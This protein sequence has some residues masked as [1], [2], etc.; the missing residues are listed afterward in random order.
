MTCRQWTKNMWQPNWYFFWL[1]W[2]FKRYNSITR[3]MSSIQKL[4]DRHYELVNRY[5]ILFLKL[6][7]RLPFHSS[8]IDKTFTGQIRVTRWMYYKKQNHLT[9]GSPPPPPLVALLS[10]LFIVF[11]YVRSVTCG[12]EIHVYSCFMFFVFLVF[13]LCRVTSVAHVSALSI[14]TWLFSFFYRLLW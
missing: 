10:L 7:W 11:I 4:N 8:D 5:E 6:R 1:Y 9:L 2:K 13:V 3:L 14:L 12:M